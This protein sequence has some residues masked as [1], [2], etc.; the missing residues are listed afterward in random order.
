MLLFLT[1]SCGASEL[2]H[3]EDRPVLQAR[4]AQGLAAALFSVDDT[5]HGDELGA[6]LAQ[7]SAGLQQ[8]AARRDHVLDHGQPASRDLAAL[9]KPAGP[10][11]LRLLPDEQRG[12]PGDL[13]ND[14]GERNSAQLE[15]GNGAGLVGKEPAS[16]YPTSR[17]SAGGFEAVLVE[18][19]WAMIPDRSRKLPVRCA[20]SKMRRASAARS[21]TSTSHNLLAQSATPSPNKRSPAAGWPTS[22]LR[23]KRCASAGRRVFR[24]A[25]ALAA[26]YA[27]TRPRTRSTSRRLRRRLATPPRDENRT[28]ADREPRQ[29]K[30]NAIGLVTHRVLRAVGG[31]RARERVERRSPLGGQRLAGPGREG[32]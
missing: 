12:E 17:K 15:P 29:H 27:S 26:P 21:S 5:Q 30:G 20:V 32:L 14:G 28:P 2:S 18:D 31:T 13:R 22:P 19:S 11:G 3:G 24:S 23:E 6:L 7:R 1:R 16:A 10:V 4:G 9:G 8:L 25:E